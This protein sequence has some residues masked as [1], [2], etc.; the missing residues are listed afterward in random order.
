MTDGSRMTGE[1]VDEFGD[2]AGVEVV[3]DAGMTVRSRRWAVAL[4]DGGIAF[5]D[6]DAIEPIDS[7]G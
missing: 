2:L 7:D 3:V 1:I 5:V 4:N 6:D